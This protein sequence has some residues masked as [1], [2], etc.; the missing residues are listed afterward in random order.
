MSKLAL[1]G[2]KPLF[3]ER[4]GADYYEYFKWPIITKEDEDAVLD[5]V[6]KNKGA[7]P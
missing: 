5:I 4:Q 3:E 2:G 6:R 7:V 1:L